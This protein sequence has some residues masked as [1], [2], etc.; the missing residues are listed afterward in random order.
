MIITKKLFEFLGKNNYVEGF[1]LDDKT[2]E[3]VFMRKD[4]S[5]FRTKNPGSYEALIIKL[6]KAKCEEGNINISK[7]SSGDN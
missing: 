6:E 3:I 7:P 1:L 5:L 2:G 4:Y